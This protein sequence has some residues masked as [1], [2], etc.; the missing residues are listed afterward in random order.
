[1][2][3]YIILTSFTLFSITALSGIATFAPGL[4]EIVTFPCKI[5]AAGDWRGDLIWYGSKKF[6]VQTSAMFSS[7]VG[8][9]FHVE[10]HET[11]QY[12]KSYMNE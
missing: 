7:S 10:L 9:S 5:A 4:A 8:N 6:H 11:Y 2:I 3:Y 1:M 12:P